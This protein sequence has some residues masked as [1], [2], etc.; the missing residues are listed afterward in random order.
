MPLSEPIQVTEPL[1]LT[2]SFG[3]LMLNGNDTIY[4]G[5]DTTT[6][7]LQLDTT[8]EGMVVA[9]ISFDNGDGPS[10]FNFSIE[11]SV[12]QP[13]SG[14]APNNV[15]DVRSRLE[16]Y[17][18]YQGEAITVTDAGY[19]GNDLD[20]EGDPLTSSIVT[21][22]RFGTLADNGNGT[23]QYSPYPGFVGVDSFRYRAHDDSEPD[24]VQFSTPV[25]VTIDVLRAPPELLD[26]A[27]KPNVIQVNSAADTVDPND[28]QLTLREAVLQA[29]ASGGGKNIIELPLGNAPIR[30][31]LGEIVVQSNL[32]IRG[33]ENGTEIWTPS[34]FRLFRIESGYEV[35][36]SDLVLSG[37]QINDD[38]GRTV[39]NVSGAAILNAGDLSLERVYLFGH[40]A[41]GPSNGRGGAIFNG[42]GATLSIRDSTFAY[43]SAYLDGG[44]IY[45]S[46]GATLSILNTTVSGNSSGLWGGGI[47]NVGD[48]EILSSTIVDN[49]AS[50]GASVAT[51]GT[52]AI[53]N[54]IAASSSSSSD[55]EGQVQ[56]LGG[57]LIGDATSSSG[58]ST[59]SGDQ[60]GDEFDPVSPLVGP[61]QLNG[62]FTPTHMLMAG[63]PAVDAGTNVYSFADQRGAA[64]VVDGLEYDSPDD[65][66]RAID[67]GAVEFG[68]FF[69]NVMDDLVDATPLGDGR[70]DVDLTTPGDQ[71]SLRAAIQEHSAMAGH[72]ADSG[73]DSG[74]YEATVLFDGTDNLTVPLDLRG[75]DEQ[76]SATGDLDLFGDIDIRGN[77]IDGTGRQ[78]TVMGTWS[79]IIGATFNHDR[80][81][82]DGFD[83]VFHVHP[84]TTAEFA[85]LKITDGVALFGAGN[86][87]G[88]GI[89]NQQ[90]TTFLVETVIDDN[91][92]DFGGGIYS[93]RATTVVERDSELRNNRASDG[94]GVYVDSSEFAIYDSAIRNNL[95][96]RYG[97]GVYVAS[98]NAY[99]GEGATIERNQ[100]QAQPWPGSN[101]SSDAMNS[102]IDGVAVYVHSGN[103]ILDR[104]LIRANGGLSTYS[105]VGAK[106]LA[107]Y[108]DNAE[109]AFYQSSEIH[110]AEQATARHV[111]LDFCRPIR[112]PFLEFIL[113]ARQ[114]FLAVGGVECRNDDHFRIQ[115]SRQ[116]TIVRQLSHGH[117]DG[118]RH[119]LRQQSDA[120]VSAVRGQ[121]YVS[122]LIL[123]AGR[124]AQRVVGGIGRSRVP[125]RPDLRQ[126]P[127]DRCI[128]SKPGR[129]LDHR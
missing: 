35:K 55:V 94:A 123:R 27:E 25:G 113:S 59:A 126:R 118:E 105:Y 48:A 17:S 83:R 121:S 24:A 30:L 115:V 6:F 58:F 72:Q 128:D 47:Y 10:T 61:L 62:G 60:F 32:E 9:D 21:Q 92:A 3:S 16:S 52:L 34:D 99:I 74:T 23:F 42:P 68:T 26:I 86:P 56:S 33:G 93:D 29:N 82:F 124:A 87:G 50:T 79:E 2:E 84:N 104:A 69:V 80:A 73:F 77:L 125:V 1:A 67:I 71:I 31:T 28:S 116:R 38:V 88:G 41:D 89:L 57:N 46:L 65:A 64:R 95:F 49:T 112:P 114:L 107:F 44:A 66:L 111:R 13:E 75:P 78:V 5:S 98:G 54:T 102:Q 108:N 20:P 22:P 39:S 40:S 11:Y 103:A 127:T 19:L 63:S 120:A 7:Q 110:V 70:V 91:M 43:N 96:A 106:I 100:L 45:N 90:G 51:V 37:R 18:T 122:P 4:G 129:R 101:T 117:D 14:S 76:Q 12:Y 36:L 15:I 97:G 53:A 8:T 85:S 81:S 119:R 109:D